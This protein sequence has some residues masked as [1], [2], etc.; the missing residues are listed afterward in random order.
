MNANWNQ[1][2]KIMDSNDQIRRPNVGNESIKWYNQIR[3][4]YFWQCLIKLNIK[5]PYG[6]EF[7]FLAV[8]P[9]EIMISL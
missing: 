8:S 1:S 5:L 3:S 7:L 2:S 9:T 4:M 6:I